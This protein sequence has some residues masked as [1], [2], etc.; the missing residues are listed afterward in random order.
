MADHHRCLTT[1]PTPRSGRQRQASAADSCT[2]AQ[3]PNITP[4]AGGSPLSLTTGHPHR[5]PSPMCPPSRER[6]SPDHVATHHRCSTIVQLSTTCAHCPPHPVGDVDSEHMCRTAV[7]RLAT[8]QATHIMP[9]V[10]KAG[11]PPT[12]H[13][14]AGTTLAAPPPPSPPPCVTLQ[15]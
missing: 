4:D 11:L 10:I 7:L 3:E 1:G 6:Y 8:P 13:P 15:S 14:T 12:P 5:Q 2:L 9:R